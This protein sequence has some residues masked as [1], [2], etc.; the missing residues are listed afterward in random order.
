[1]TEI[2]GTAQ[3]VLRTAGW[4]DA[5]FIS[6][7][8]SSGEVRRFLGGPVP[9]HRQPGV[10][11]GYLRPSD[12]ALTCIAALRASR[13]AVGLVFL[14][15][16]KDGED[17][18]VSYMFHPAV[19]GQGIATAAVSVMLDHGLQRF[20]LSRLIAETQVDNRPSCRLLERIGMSEL[21]RVERF[22]ALQAI[23]ATAPATDRSA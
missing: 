8:I 22:G 1:M 12:H 20:R 17:H 13:R 15:P 6:G 23:Y 18:E 9:L 5:R 16:H 3:V 7:L 11:A 14:T 19:W 21:G 10:I 2:G 4:G